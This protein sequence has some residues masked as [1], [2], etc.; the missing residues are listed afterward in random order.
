MSAQSEQPPFTFGPIATDLLGKRVQW[1]SGFGSNTI[2]HE[3]IVRA[4]V[5]YCSR[6]GDIDLRV[7]VLGDLSRFV[8]A[9]DIVRV[10]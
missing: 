10:L 8:S 9:N 6:L 2:T 1:R 5:P 4:V 3:G 7:W